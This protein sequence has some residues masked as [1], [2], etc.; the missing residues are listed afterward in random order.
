MSDCIYINII[1]CHYLQSGYVE[2]S[3]G[4]CRSNSLASIFSL[5]LIM[6]SRIFYTF[7]KYNLEMPVHLTTR[8]WNAEGNPNGKQILFG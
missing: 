5:V 8:F 1:D 2:F 6:V 3:I 4:A 7:T